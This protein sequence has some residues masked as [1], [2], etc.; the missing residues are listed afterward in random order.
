[1]KR[2]FPLMIG[3]SL[4]LAASLSFAQSPKPTETQMRDNA[5]TQ[6]RMGKDGDV[7]ARQQT[8]FKSL[9]RGGKGYLNND[10]VSG[11]PFVA[12]NFAHC[13][14]DHDGKITWDEFK[15]CTHNHTPATK[16]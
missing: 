8:Y 16:D 11:D 15:T 2:T 1:M 12:Q 9:D 7:T 10:D 4:A 6:E 14:G 3:A 5:N 13:D